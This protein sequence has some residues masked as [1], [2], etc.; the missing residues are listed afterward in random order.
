[1]RGRI[2]CET[3]KFKT[4]SESVMKRHVEINHLEKTRK[5]SKRKVC[6]ICQ[7]KFN[8]ENTFKMHMQTVH[9]HEDQNQN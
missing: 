1:M 7:K 2:I 8:K 9:E 4:T 5:T 3:C 6:N